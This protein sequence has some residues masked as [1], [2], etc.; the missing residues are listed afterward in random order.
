MFLNFSGAGGLGDGRIRGAVARVTVRSRYVLLRYFTNLMHRKAGT[1]WLGVLKSSET[2]AA[3][4]FLLLY[5]FFK[6][7]TSNEKK[8]LW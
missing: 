1:V 8:E 7:L 6:L 5:N 4:S 2:A 3:A